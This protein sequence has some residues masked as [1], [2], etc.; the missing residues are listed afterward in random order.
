MAAIVNLYRLMLTGVQF[1][2]HADSMKLAETMIRY[3]Y[4]TSNQTKG[5]KIKKPK[6]DTDM[7]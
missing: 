4:V 7:K 5:I 3:K 1:Q 6:D 2:E